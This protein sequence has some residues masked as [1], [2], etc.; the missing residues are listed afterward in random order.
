MKASVNSIDSEG[1][2]FMRFIGARSYAA[3]KTMLRSLSFIA[4]SRTL[5]RCSR[6][7]GIMIN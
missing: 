6:Q 7:G 2:S 4:W 1:E 5:L 3:L